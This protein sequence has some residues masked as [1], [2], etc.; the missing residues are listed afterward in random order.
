MITIA[1]TIWIKSSLTNSQTL[2]ST[3]VSIVFGSFGLITSFIQAL[4]IVLPGDSWFPEPT[5]YTTICRKPALTKIIDRSIPAL[6]SLAIVL[7]LVIPYPYV[8]PPNALQSVMEKVEKLTPGVDIMVYQSTF[9]PPTIVNEFVDLDGKKGKEYVFVSPYFYLQAITDT[10]NQ[11]QFF[12]I[13]T[14]SKAFTPTFSTIEFKIILGISKF[15]TISFPSSISC[16][17]GVHNYFYYET[18]A[19]SGVLFNQVYGF[20]L[21]EAGYRPK[22]LD[23]SGLYQGQT[24]YCDHKLVPE[25]NLMDLK[26][27]RGKTSFNTYAVSLHDVNKY[28]KD[29]LGVDYYE[30]GPIG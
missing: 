21:N 16:S 3:V 28:T 15:T 10:E 30:V 17:L 1:G 7:A 22:D 29:N 26:S 2:F 19:S 14:R 8:I 25:Q 24:S 5:W 13:T 4:D 11:V 23:L 6:G 27:F 18:L 9:G 12:A 20:G